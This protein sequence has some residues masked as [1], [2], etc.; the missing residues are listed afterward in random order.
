[1]KIIY[2]KN[3]IKNTVF[4]LQNRTTKKKKKK[5]S[6]HAHVIRL[7]IP[8]FLSFPIKISFTTSHEFLSSKLH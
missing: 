4:F 6:S 7:I 1:M 8:N 2:I 3:K 5:V